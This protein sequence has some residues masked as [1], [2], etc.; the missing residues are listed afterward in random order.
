MR[1]FTEERL[2]EVEDVIAEVHAKAHEERPTEERPNEERLDEAGRQR[3]RG[4][5]LRG[6]SMSKKT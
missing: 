3:P 5:L 1:A 2:E 6:G 4:G